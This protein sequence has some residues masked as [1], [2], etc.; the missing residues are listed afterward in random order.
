MNN[1]NKIYK[2]LIFDMDGTI[3]DTEI[4]WKNVN[5]V[6]LQKR[7]IN[8]ENIIKTLID[9]VHGHSSFKIASMFKH[10]LRL[11][12]SVEDIVAEKKTI[13]QTIFEQEIHYI[14]GFIE[15]HKILKKHNIPTA[16]ATNADQE[17]LN[18]TAKALKLD[19]HFAHHMYAITCVN[20]V[21]KPSPDIYLHA[22][23]KLNIDP[24]DCVALED[25]MPGVSAAKNAG[26]FCIGINT[27]KNKYLLKQADLIVDSYHEI[28][29][30]KLFGINS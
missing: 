20:N 28:P 9:R 3:V 2:A 6:F 30:S 26:M 23:N 29:I 13:A 14:E 27:A 19:K 22:A 8:D 17:G 24:H 1:V 10:D 25:S 16:I 12:D 15:F 11:K 21:C 4:L 5:R 18:R 7:N